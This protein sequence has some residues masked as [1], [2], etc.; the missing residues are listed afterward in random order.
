[1]CTDNGS[2]QNFLWCTVLHE[3]RRRNVTFRKKSIWCTQYIL[4]KEEKIKYY[5]Q[6]NLLDFTISKYTM[7]VRFADNG[8]VPTNIKFMHP[9]S[10]SLISFPVI[11]Q[12]DNNQQPIQSTGTG[13]QS[14]LLA[15]ILFPGRNQ[16][17]FWIWSNMLTESNRNFS[18]GCVFSESLSL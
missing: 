5:F 12:H 3:D 17:H 9:F 2:A 10:S 7:V 15:F 6:R 14:I 1:M 8:L 13:F 4:S 18:T 16:I 11:S